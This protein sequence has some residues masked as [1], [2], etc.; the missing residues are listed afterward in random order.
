MQQTVLIKE[1]PYL[2]SNDNEQYTNPLAQGF[3]SSLK[4]C[5]SIPPGFGLVQ[6]RVKTIQNTS[7]HACFVKKIIKSGW[8]NKTSGLPLKHH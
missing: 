3:S 6:L 7:I 1:V 8:E 4:N 5:S 2:T